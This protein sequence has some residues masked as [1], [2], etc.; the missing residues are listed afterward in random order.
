M[1]RSRIYVARTVHPSVL[2][3][4]G[5][6]GE[7]RAWEGPDRCPVE[8]LEKEIAEVDAVLGTYRWTAAM[9][10]KAPRLRLIALTSVGFDMA[11]I[12]AATQRNIL[13]TN[14]PDVLTETVADLTFA[15]MLAASRR[16]CELD[17]WLRAGQWKD[18]AVSP[19]AWDIHHATLGIIGLGRIGSAVARRAL[20]FQ[21]KVLYYDTT[22][23]GE[24]EKQYG[25]Q[26]VDRETLLR[27]SDVVT[28]H[29]P[30]SPET[31][32]MFGAA[33]LALMKRSAFLIN[34]S[35]GPVVDE[36]A[37]ISA[38]QAGRIAGAGLDVFEQ[39][40]VDLANPLLKMENVV[41]LPHVGSATAVTRTAMLDLAINNVLAVLQGK[42]PLTP[43]NPEVLARWKK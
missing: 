1:S 36:R 38:L 14:T 34:T 4:L 37:L 29:V 43:V 11:D 15:L 28:L 17:R 39:E 35:R 22:R 31:R 30:L 3:R 13:V 9:M 27:E 5:A 23:K 8:V 16:I 19:M 42:P 21:M 6:V 12:A 24:L 33:Q 25:C 20:A 2:A 41:V 7:T 18:A 10:D 40:P 32:G 26:Y